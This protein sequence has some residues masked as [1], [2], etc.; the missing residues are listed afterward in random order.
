MAMCAACADITQGKRRAPGHGALVETGRDKQ[1]WGTGAVVTTRY[2][3]SECGT[4]WEYED[5]KNDDGAG[6]TEVKS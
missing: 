1:N 5:D 6:W 3:C 4:K 2:R